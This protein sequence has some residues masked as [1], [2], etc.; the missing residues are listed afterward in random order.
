MK[1]VMNLIELIEFSINMMKFVI[2][3][4]NLIKSELFRL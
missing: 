3:L 1:F 2:D 4:M